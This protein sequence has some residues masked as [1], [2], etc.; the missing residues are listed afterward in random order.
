[1]QGMLNMSSYALLVGA[2]GQHVWHLPSDG[3]IPVTAARC[4]M[5]FGCLSFIPF[6][7]AIRRRAEVKKDD[8]TGMAAFTVIACILSQSVST[9]LTT[10]IGP[11]FSTCV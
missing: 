1:M 8:W 4:L 11:L 9:G 7:L 10:P 6:L 5:Y 2:I 3:H